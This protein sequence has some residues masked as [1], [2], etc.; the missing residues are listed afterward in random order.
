MNISIFDLDT[1]IQRHWWHWRMHE[2]TRSAKGMGNVEKSQ[3]RSGNADGGWRCYR[4]YGSEAVWPWDRR[5]FGLWA[6]AAQMHVQVILVGCIG[7][8]LSRRS[9]KNKSGGVAWG[10]LG[11]G[12]ISRSTSEKTKTSTK[13]LNRINEIEFCLFFPYQKMKDTQNA[14]QKIECP[15]LVN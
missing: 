9:I 12:A 11:A 14:C 13:C 2:Y 15:I 7:C 10:R 4:A 6:R 5:H 3:R 1:S 8:V